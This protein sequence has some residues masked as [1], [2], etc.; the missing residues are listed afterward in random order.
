MSAA[1]DLVK[2]LSVDGVE[3][4]TDGKSIRWRNGD[5]RRL[6]NPCATTSA[7]PS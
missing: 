4:S 2:S 5:G 3:F 7:K 6:L 1:L